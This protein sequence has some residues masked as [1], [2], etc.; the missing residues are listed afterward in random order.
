[1]VYNNYTSELDRCT[2]EKNIKDFLINFENIKNDETKT[3]GIYI[4]G[5]TGVGKSELVKNIINELDMDS[6]WYNASDVRNKSVLETITNQNMSNYNVMSLFKKKKQNI[7][8]VMDEIDGMIGGE[9]GCMTNIIKLI[10]AKKTKKQKMEDALNNPIICIGGNKL[11]K[12]VKDLMKVC[13]SFYVGKPTNTQIEKIISSYY[14]QNEKKELIQLIASKCQN[15][16]HKIDIMVNLIKKRDNID[17]KELLSDYKCFQQDVKEIVLNLFL[18]KS[19]ME[20][21]NIT[22]IDND[23]T[24]ASLIWHENV[25][26]QMKTHDSN[27]LKTYYDI[28]NNICFSDFIDRVTFQKQIWQFN[29]MTSLMKTYYSN[30]ILHKGVEDKKISLKSESVLKNQ[31]IIFTKVLTKYSNEYSN[32]IFISNLCE[33]LM[34]DKKD[35]LGFFYWIN[36][37]NGDLSTI[38]NIVNGEQVLSELEINRML[39][40]IDNFT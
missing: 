36:T 33:T 37:N 13:N 15:D 1:M 40:F 14:L 38:N 29:E 30:Y 21:H 2:I 23:R 12:R 22:L 9:K 6:I 19:E 25:I 10:R 20:N 27:F 7:V 34:I 4:Y 32:T 8:I 39:K 11:D 16:L 31:E 24:I 26:K 3:K 28:L 18:N 5:D 35:L 17:A